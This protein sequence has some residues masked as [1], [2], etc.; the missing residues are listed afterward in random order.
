MA[1]GEEPYSPEYGSLLARKNLTRTFSDRDHFEAVLNYVVDTNRFTIAVVFPIIGA[2]LLLASAEQLLPSVLAFNPY[3]VLVGVFVMRLPLVSGILP[4]IGRRAGAALAVLFG[5]TYA[6]EYIGATTGFPYGEF[7]YSVSLGPMLLGTIPL[8]LPLFFVPLVV[9]SYLLCLLVLGPRANSPALRI[10]AV[11]A[12]VVAVDLVLDPGAVALG[13]WSFGD[14]GFYG[15]PP[16]NYA[17]WVL[18]AIV[19]TLLI[20]AAFDRTAL[21]SRVRNCPYML[22]DLVSFILLWGAI[23]AFYHAWAPFALAVGFG[24]ALLSTDHFDFDVRPI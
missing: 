5:Y 20:D 16:M 1:D 4:L 23:N 3:L 12:T 2:G 18:S 19:A 14:G 24:V 21:L 11:A 9:N 13:F 10:P 8:A 17:G 22:D 7:S 6:I 15:V